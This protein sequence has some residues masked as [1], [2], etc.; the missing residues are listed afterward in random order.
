MGS[1][2]RN[3]MVAY[4]RSL[5]LGSRRTDKI[6]ATHATRAERDVVRASLG[7]TQLAIRAA[8]DV[9]GLPLFLS[10]ILPEADRA[11]VVRSALYQREE[12]AAWTPDF[13]PLPRFSVFYFLSLLL[14]AQATL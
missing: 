5:L 12:V 7:Q 10:I 14:I 13:S 2:F 4:W 11:D 9:P 3:L 1:T 8:G 6:Q